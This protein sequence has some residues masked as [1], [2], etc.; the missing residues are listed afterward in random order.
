MKKGEQNTSHCEW[1]IIL[2]SKIEIYN[3]VVS[4]G[5]DLKSENL[6]IPTF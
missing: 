4:I 3:T 6:S 1:N 2:D 5:Y